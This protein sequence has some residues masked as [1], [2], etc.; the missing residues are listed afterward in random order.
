MKK[1]FVFL[2]LASLIMACSDKS[3]NSA[4]K[5]GAA[6]NRKTEA[7]TGDA[8]VQASLGDASGLIYNITSDSA[9]HDVAG[10][11]YNGLVK[12]DKNLNIAGD[13]AKSWDISDDNKTITFHLYDNIKWH[14]GVPFT[15]HDVDFTYR[16]MIDNST[17]TSYDADFRLVKS[18]ETPDNLTVKVTYGEPFAPALISW[19][20]AMLPKHLLEGQEAAKSPLMR[21]PVGTGP[22][23]FKEWKSG[24]SI[25]LIA[26]DDYFLGRPNIDRMVY[27]IIPDM[28]TMFL[29]LLNGTL[30][31]MGLTPVQ[32]TKQTGTAQFKDNY[33]KY[34]YLSSG[35]SYIGYNL[36]NPLFSDK[37]VR[38]ALTYATP[39]QEIVDGILFGEGSPATGP[40]KPGTVWYNPD[41]KKYPYDIEK[42]KALLAEAGWSDTD[43]DGIIDKDGKP[44]EFQLMTNQ[45]N[46][47]RIKTAETVQQHWQKLGIKID[48]RVLEW[49]AFI[50]E[51]IDK[52]KFDAV[53][54]GWN[55]V[56]DPDPYDVWHSSKCGPKKLNFICFNNAEADEM[57]E[58]GRHEMNP[59]ERKKYYDRFQE[60]LAEEQPYT[61]LYI[62][63]ALVALSN[64]FK[65][66]EAAPA[67]IAYNVED[68][69]VPSAKQKYHF[70]Q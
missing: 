58:K 29:E 39:K 21:S 18:L 62:P 70:Q 59:R 1:A 24:E 44:F 61:F 65:N 52:Q 4:G 26:N 46:S 67:G 16:F 66:V 57:I 17:P 55:I 40:Y 38:Q 42:A 23:K 60:I 28:N 34:T 12:L 27:R 30:D 20:I 45:G 3:E 53:I 51:Y 2:L 31:L 68:W 43:G 15:S 49:A 22:F 64:R 7:V 6:Q 37:R 35:Y 33:D 11:I 50:N 19:G 41:V 9:S 8:L 48:I 13:L 25:T 14:D 69:Y 5:D 54:L 56:Q 36:N 63:N 10:N 32:W 47:L